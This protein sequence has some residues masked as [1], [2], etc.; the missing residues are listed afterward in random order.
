MLDR[1]YKMR[2]L[3]YGHLESLEELKVSF[4]ERIEIENHLYNRETAKHTKG[5]WV[6]LIVSFAICM[7]GYYVGKYLFV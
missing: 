3:G 5:K 2:A 7:L 6:I 1:Y 4:D